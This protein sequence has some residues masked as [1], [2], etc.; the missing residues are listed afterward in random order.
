MYLIA[1]HLFYSVLEVS[2][3]LMNSEVSNFV[4]TDKIK[5]N[6]AKKIP[7]RVNTTT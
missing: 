7:L 3:Q 1:L 2:V 6:N 4:S 5:R